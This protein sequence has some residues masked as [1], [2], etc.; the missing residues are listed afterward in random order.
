[1]DNQDPIKKLSIAELMEVV[2]GMLDGIKNLPLHAMLT[3]INN[4]DLINIL[5]LF[6]SF[7]LADKDDKD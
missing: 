6:K 7:L 2:D 5:H 1:M 3:P 4:Y